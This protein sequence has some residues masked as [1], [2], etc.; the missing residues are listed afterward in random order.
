MHIKE[1]L[2]NDWLMLA[3]KE[4]CYTCENFSMFG[5]VVNDDLFLCSHCVE[6]L[7]GE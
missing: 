7:G 1:K 2:P 5:K 4:E 6:E 3:H